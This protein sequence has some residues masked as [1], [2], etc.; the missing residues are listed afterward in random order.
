[1]TCTSTAWGVAVGILLA[2]APLVAHHSVAAEFDL[3][4]PI[5][6]KGTITRITAKTPIAGSTST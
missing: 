1:M 6:Q 2:A 5:T 4:K 3:D